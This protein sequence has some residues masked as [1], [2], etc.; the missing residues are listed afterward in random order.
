MIT[1]ITI[2]RAGTAYYLNLIRGEDIV[3]MNQP[4]ARER[5]VQIAQENPG[6]R[7]EGGEQPGFSPLPSYWIWHVE[8]QEELMPA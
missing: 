3:A 7:V 2:R 6:G 1:K 4:I 8:V 5:A